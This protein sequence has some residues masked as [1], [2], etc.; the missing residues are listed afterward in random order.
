MNDEDEEYENQRDILKQMQYEYQ[1]K[2][3][4]I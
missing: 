1:V 4:G 3:W 2:S